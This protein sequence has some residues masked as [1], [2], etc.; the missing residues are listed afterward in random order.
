MKRRNPFVPFPLLLLTLPALYNSTGDVPAFKIV[1]LYGSG[2]VA[3]AVLAN[4]IFFLR[5]KR[6]P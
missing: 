6:E 5:S 3:G 4:F 1:A 2:A